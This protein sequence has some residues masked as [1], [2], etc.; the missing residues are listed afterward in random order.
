MNKN[1][2]VFLFSVVFLQACAVFEVSLSIKRD[3]KV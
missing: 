1:L 3:A 2:I